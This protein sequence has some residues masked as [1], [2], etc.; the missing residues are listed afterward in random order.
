MKGSKVVASHCLKQ[1]PEKDT[2]QMERVEFL[3]DSGMFES[4]KNG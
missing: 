3:S 2:Y 1:T 4:Q